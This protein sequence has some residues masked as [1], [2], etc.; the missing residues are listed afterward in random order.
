MYLH[1]IRVFSDKLCVCMI[2][3]GSFREIPEANEI[4][5]NTRHIDYDEYTIIEDYL[6]KLSDHQKA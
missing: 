6:V 2:L 1:P 5:Q 3:K 4:T